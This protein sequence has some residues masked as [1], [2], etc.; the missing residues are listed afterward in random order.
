M[1]KVVKSLKLLNLEK[2]FSRCVLCVFGKM[3]I[4]CG[5]YSLTD[6]ELQGFLE[7]F[8]AV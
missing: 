5:I 7:R 3:Y 6:V 8:V 4:S 2:V 1:L